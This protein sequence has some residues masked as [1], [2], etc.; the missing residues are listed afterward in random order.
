MKKILFAG[1]FVIVLL[2]NVLAQ[3]THED[4][5]YLKNGSIIRG[6]IIENLVGEY[7]KIETVGRNV[8]VFKVDEISRI[9]MESLIPFSERKELRSN[10]FVI[11]AEVGM[12]A[13]KSSN[14]KVS[15]Q[16]ISSYQFRNRI[17]A[18]LGTGFEVFDIQTLPVF[19][20]VRYKIF[21]GGVNPYVYAQCGYSIPLS[22][23]QDLYNVDADGGIMYGTGIGIR[24]NFS[25]GSGF[26]I[27]VGYRYQQIDYT[28]DSNYW[29]YSTQ[30]ERT[31]L[32]RKVALKIGFIF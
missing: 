30:Y 18:G 11:S 12:L 17:S 21:N 19:C 24:K 27:S 1:L 28:S 31:D 32:Y 20:D 3:E 13:N 7:T 29:G 9:E 15:L 8:W 6:K 14:E 23:N 16:L 25:N 10:S 22:K 5:V 4:V 26:T 2:T